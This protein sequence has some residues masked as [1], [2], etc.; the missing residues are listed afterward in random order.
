MTQE[1]FNK[2]IPGKSIVKT[3]IDGIEK[4]MLFKYFLCNIDNFDGYWML[5]TENMETKSPLERE[6]S[7]LETYAN[8]CE[9]VS[10]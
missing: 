5:C 6:D 1:E 8:L 3:T 9:V 2:L 4:T 7:D 10:F